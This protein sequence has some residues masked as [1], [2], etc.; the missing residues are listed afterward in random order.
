MARTQTVTFTTGAIVGYHTIYAGGSDS[1][2]AVTQTGSW[3]TQAYTIQSA[4]MTYTRSTLGNV[5]T[6]VR[7]TNGT[8]AYLSDSATDSAWTGTK[9]VSLTKRAA[10][11]QGLTQITLSGDHGTAGTIAAGS[12]IIITVVC[13]LSESKSTFT[14][15]DT[16]TG[17]RMSLTVTRGEG[18]QRHACRLIFG[19]QSLDVS[20]TGDAIHFD[21]PDAWAQE[22]PSSASGTATVILESYGTKSNL[23]GSD[24]HYV[25]IRVDPAVVPSVSIDVTQLET[26]LNG[27]LLEGIGKALIEATAAG[28]QGSTVSTYTFPTGDGGSITTTADSYTTDQFSNLPSGSATETR[29][30]TVTVTDSRGRTASASASVTLYAYQPPSIDTDENRS[31]SQGSADPA[32]TYIACAVDP[33]W[34]QIDGNTATLR[35]Q[36]GYQSL[37]DGFNAQISDGHQVHVIGGA[38]D[39]QYIYQVRYTLTDAVGK[40]VTID[41]SIPT[42]STFMVWD[43]ANNAIGFGGYPGGSDRLYISDSWDIYIGQQTLADYIRSIINS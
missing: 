39:T 33:V 19:S 28:A 6:W 25:T 9:T 40:A 8:E 16:D 37:V 13:A 43:A 22:I 35:I 32:G 3:P 5:G 41:R 30:L 15:P 24:S 20:T 14:A 26:R 27:K 34:S 42:G 36:Y 4:S 17:D 23:I 7:K 10:A 11:Y 21:I 31:D 2:F 29:T 12:T 18:V 1:V 38:V